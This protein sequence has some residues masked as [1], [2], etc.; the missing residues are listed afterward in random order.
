MHMHIVNNFHTFENVYDAK[1]LS[2]LAKARLLL[3]Y[4]VAAQQHQAQHCAH[5][6]LGAAVCHDDGQLWKIPRYTLFVP[7]S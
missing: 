7:R 2:I 5:A 6:L 4:S 1:T 3:P